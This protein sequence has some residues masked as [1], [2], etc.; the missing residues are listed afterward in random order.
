MK[1]FA[2]IGLFLLMYF[3][4]TLIVYILSF[5]VLSWHTIAR[6]PMML[7]FGSVISFMTV[8]AY[9]LEKEQEG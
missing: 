9:R 5:D 6:N 8:V 7:L 4:L 1:T 3:M 2:N